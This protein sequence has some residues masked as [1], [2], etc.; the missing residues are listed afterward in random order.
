MQT[1]PFLGEL[2]GTMVLILLGDGVV[3][4]VWVKELSDG[5]FLYLLGTVNS[6]FMGQLYAK[7]WTIETCFQG[8][9]SRG[10]DIEKTH[11]KCLK[12]IKKLIALVSIAYALCGSMGIYYH[13]KVQNIKK[14]KHG[15]KSN[16]FVR[17][18]LNMI[19]E[20][21]RTT[22]TLDATIE[23]RIFSLLRWIKIQV[24]HYQLLKKAG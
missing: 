19:R 2:I 16:S 11:L 5:D 23:N 18:G 17:K 10:F 12:K 15:Y 14:K 1:S 20:L 8:L 13:K 9:K 4:N 3:A 21:F 7:R 6:D 24:A 22:L